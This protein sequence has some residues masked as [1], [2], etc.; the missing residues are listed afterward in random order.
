MIKRH[1]RE[2]FNSSMFV[3]GVA[4]VLASLATAVWMFRVGDIV[5]ALGLGLLVVA[6]LLLAGI[7]LSPEATAH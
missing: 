3:T 2:P 1:D 5:T 7:G 6:G 4:L